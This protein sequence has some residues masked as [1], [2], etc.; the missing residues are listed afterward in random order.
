MP[1]WKTRRGWAGDEPEAPC[2]AVKQGGRDM[3]AGRAAAGAEAGAGSAGERGVSTSCGWGRVIRCV[4]L[5]G[6]P[7]GP[8]PG[9]GAPACLRT[10]A[11]GRVLSPPLPLALT[12]SPPNVAAELPAR[13]IVPCFLSY[14]RACGVCAPLGACACACEQ[15]CECACARRQAGRPAGSRGG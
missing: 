2:G 4:C 10:C 12:F 9:T 13:L 3:P 15:T 7:V 1:R 8:G 11:L 6:P 14:V 5:F